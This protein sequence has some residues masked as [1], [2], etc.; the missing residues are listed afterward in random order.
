MEQQGHFLFLQ[1]NKFKNFYYLHEHI[2]LIK[3]LVSY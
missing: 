3:F 1:L 2:K